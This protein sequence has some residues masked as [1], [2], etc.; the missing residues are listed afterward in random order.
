MAT[1]NDRLLDRIVLASMAENRTTRN[2]AWSDAEDQFLRDSLATMTDAEIGEQLG[3]S[4]MA[5][6]LRWSRDLHLPSRSKHPDI[7][8]GRRAAAMLGIDEHKISHWIDVGLIPGRL[9][10]GMQSKWHM[11]H[12]V[13]RQ[14]FRRWVLNP[15]NWVYFNPKKVRDP[16]LNR[17]LKKRAKR[18]GDEWWTTRQVADYHGVQVKNVMQTI[19]RGR[20]RSFHLTVSLGGRH[21]NPGWTN[22]FVLRSD[23]K[24]AV[25]YTGKGSQ[26]KISKFTHAADRWILKAR[27]QLGMTF[28]AIGRTMKIGKSSYYHDTNNTIAYRYRQLKAL[29]K[30]KRKRGQS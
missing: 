5:V 11:I 27:D 8:T 22:H 18:W 6:H 14:A 26:K 20:L 21:P 9:M 29:Q 13:N 24:A 15:M 17:M 7:L 12:L 3:R 1:L 30:T 16:E 2:R 4:E 25:F 19:R 28:I 23:A 10:P